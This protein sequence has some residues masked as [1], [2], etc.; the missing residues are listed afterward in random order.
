[1]KI[2]KGRCGVA[3]STI[4][5]VA[6][7]L[8]FT[9]ALAG[10]NDDT[11][12]AALHLEIANLDAYYD[13]AG[14]V[15]VMNRHIWDP[16]FFID[17]ATSELVP[18]LASG[19]SF[20]DDK[21]LDVTLRKGVIFH[22]GSVMDAADV[23]YTLNWIKDP[24][25]K[26]KSVSNANWIDRVEILDPYK[27]RIHMKKPNALALRFLSLFPI[28]PEGVYEKHGVAAMN[29]EPIGTG[30]Y[31]VKS[32]DLGKKYVL[33]R[34]DE[35]YADSPKGRAKIAN[36]EISIIPE[37]A[38]QIAEMMSGKLN[39]IYKV[40]ADQ[41]SQMTRMKSLSVESKP[42]SRMMYIVLDAAGRTGPDSPFKSL[43]V[44]QAIAHAIDR[45]GIVTALVQGGAQV[46]H[47]FCFPQDFG[48]PKDAVQYEYNPG[49]ARQLL[50]EAGYP[51]GFEV[52]FSAWRDRPYVEAIMSNLADVG[53]KANLN[54]I[55]LA[56]LRGQWESGEL[57]MVYGSIGSRIEDIGNFVP[58]FFG[59]SKRDIAQDDE[60][61]SL[62][63]KAGSSMD[64]ETRRQLNY[65]ALRRIA[66]QA[67]AVPMFSDNMN[68]VM[69]SD[70]MVPSDSGGTPHFYRA[71]W[72]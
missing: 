70:V 62:L 24:A 45:Q 71:E 16:L 41:S 53:I 69:S 52:T 23:A 44:R 47:A 39:W 15:V 19:S 7:A 14:S 34:F 60:V 32:M 35:H 13:S 10:K 43:K 8:P 30:P 48:C 65:Q 63:S 33:E 37:P 64:E 28:H 55:K 49:K 1:M 18:A 42:T 5:G 57:P 22:D 21:T 4:L 31:R 72:R 26:I 29:I 2:I 12:R 56:P 67:L 38:T 68:F 25:N 20:I 66:D 61:A 17:P 50:A 9:S 59:K 51:N 40:P 27:V 36:L 6:A 46:L 3:L 11:L 54:F 58:T